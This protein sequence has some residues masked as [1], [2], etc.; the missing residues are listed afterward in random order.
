MTI[1]NLDDSQDDLIEGTPQEPH[2]MLASIL[3]EILKEGAVLIEF[4][5][6]TPIAD[7]TVPSAIL[8]LHPDEC[9]I[10]QRPEDADTDNIWCWD[11]G[12]NNWFQLNFFQVET[13]QSWPPESFVTE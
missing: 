10:D 3:P 9:P 12:Q 7:G 8:T 6:N 5:V 11:I 13:A 4:K 1:D 2:E